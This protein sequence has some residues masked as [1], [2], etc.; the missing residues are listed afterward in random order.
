MLY[1]LKFFQG[2]SL[3]YILAF[4]VYFVSSLCA[5]FLTREEDRLAALGS[6]GSCIPAEVAKVKQEL[7]NNH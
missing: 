3:L 4:K 2:I 6:Y 7:T 1:F 5:S